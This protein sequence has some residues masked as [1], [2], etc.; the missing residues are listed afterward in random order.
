MEDTYHFFYVAKS[1]DDCCRNPDIYP[2]RDN[3]CREYARRAIF[4][5]EEYINHTQNYREL[6]YA[7][8]I[9]EMAY[10]SFYAMGDI[11]KHLGE[12]EKAMDCCIRAEDFCP[13]RNEHIVCLAECFMHMG[14]YISMKEQTKKLV[15]ENRKLPFPEYYFLINNNF[16]PDSGTYGKYLHQIA[17]ENT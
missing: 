2:L 5:Y 4:Y 12:Y 10:F 15:D 6:G 1:Y 3:H 8:G 17:C 11:Y 7:Q 16:Y 9:N 13:V 14:D